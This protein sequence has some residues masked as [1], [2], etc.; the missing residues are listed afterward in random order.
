[1][2]YNA[3]L[4]L[5]PQPMDINDRNNQGS[6]LA[7]GDKED[8][9]L[10][11]SEEQLFEYLK[12]NNEEIALFYA[13]KDLA[14]MR[15]FANLDE[16]LSVGVKTKQT[17]FYWP[18][19]GCICILALGDISNMYFSAMTC[20]ARTESALE[21]YYHNDYVEG[22]RGG[23]FKHICVSMLLRRYLSA[24]KAFLIMDVIHEGITNPN[25]FARDTHMDLHNNIIGRE[26]KYW[27]F[28][29]SYYGD[30]YNSDLWI[31]RMYNFV[32]NTNNGVYK[33]WQTYH[34]FW[35]LTWERTIHPCPNK[36]VYY[37]I[38]H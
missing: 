24:A 37:E 35:Y 26:T 11:M 13:Y 21:T 36:Y 29:G 12:L 2:A 38:N 25:E 17:R 15:D 1:M 7:Y 5:H 8:E 31:L 6:A 22:G 27:T 4:A 30:M 33:N 14:R 20:K 3:Y 28:R 16:I 23:A 9:V 19:F 34:S 18:N 32:Q 10:L